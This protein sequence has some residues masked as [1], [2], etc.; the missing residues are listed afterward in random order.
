MMG[1]AE[2]ESAIYADIIKEYY[3][4]TKYTPNSPLN[5]RLRQT[6]FLHF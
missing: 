6:D 2:G 4:L 5:D 1:V 3:N